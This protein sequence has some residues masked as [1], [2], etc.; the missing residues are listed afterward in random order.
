MPWQAVS[1]MSLR[2]EVVVLATA[3]DA[4]STDAAR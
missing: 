3:K 1:T 2:H 4:S